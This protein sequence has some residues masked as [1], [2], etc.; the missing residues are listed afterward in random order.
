[1]IIT[2]MY[3]LKEFLDGMDFDWA[4]GRIIYQ[5]VGEKQYPALD[6]P[7]NAEEITADHEILTTEFDASY[8]EYACPRFIAEDAEAFYFPYYYDGSTAA[9]KVWK[10]I[11]KYLDYRTNKTPYPGGG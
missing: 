9:T 1:M 5:A 4:T 10:D 2:N 7:V 11:D 6:D 8:S 3:T